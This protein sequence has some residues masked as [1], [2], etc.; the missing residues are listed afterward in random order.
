ME[1][2]KEIGVSVDTGEETGMLSQHATDLLI[3]LMYADYLDT[4]SQSNQRTVFRGGKSFFEIF[5]PLTGIKNRTTLK[6]ARW[7]LQA[8]GALLSDQQQTHKH[9]HLAATPWQIFKQFNGIM[10]SPVRASRTYDA[11]MFAE[12]LK[13][14]GVD[15]KNFPLN[16]DG[17]VMVQ[18]AM[19]G[20]R[21]PLIY[22]VSQ[23]AY[24]RL[25]KA[26]LAMKIAGSCPDPANRRSVMIQTWSTDPA[27][28]SRWLHAGMPTPQA[29][30][31]HYYLSVLSSPSLELKND[32][33]QLVAALLH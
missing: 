25:L 26:E 6:R 19:F 17:V 30:P 12:L 22:A 14:S 28:V 13:F 3:G 2:S 15:S 27:L 10:A 7:E 1:S 5:A 18:A 9:Y 20:S 11:N 23:Q 31:L 24:D 8:C 4:S 33:A 29:D 32:A 21:R 16:T